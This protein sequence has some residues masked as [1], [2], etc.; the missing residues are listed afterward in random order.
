[1]HW[2]DFLFD[3]TFHFQKDLRKAHRSIYCT[4]QALCS[5]AVFKTHF[6]PQN[7]LVLTYTRSSTNQY[8]SFSNTFI[9]WHKSV[10]IQI[11]QAVNN[12][13]NSLASFC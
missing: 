12:S 8:K 4:T 9:E 1:M 10:D 7:T 3:I 11:Q 5:V 2:Y 13:E 6:L